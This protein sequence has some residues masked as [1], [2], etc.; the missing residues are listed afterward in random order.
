MTHGKDVIKEDYKMEYIVE[1]YK[2]EEFLFF[3][4]TKDDIIIFEEN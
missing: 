4:K 1:D 2:L 3:S